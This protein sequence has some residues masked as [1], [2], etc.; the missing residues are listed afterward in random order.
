MVCHGMKF[1]VF[2]CFILPP[3]NHQFGAQC[4]GQFGLTFNMFMGLVRITQGTWD[5]YFKISILPDFNDLMSIFE[6]VEINI[7]I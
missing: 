6:I 1:F 4:H 3:S 7:Y 5:S 2:F